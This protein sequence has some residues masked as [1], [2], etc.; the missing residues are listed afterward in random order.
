MRNTWQGIASRSWH[1]RVRD[2]EGLRGM[3]QGEVAFGCDNLNSCTS[4]AV[5]L[6]G[7]ALVRLQSTWR[8]AVSW[9]PTAVSCQKGKATTVSTTTF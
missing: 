1:G 4:N 7:Q 6:Q 2:R 5:V 3:R 8:A 9:V